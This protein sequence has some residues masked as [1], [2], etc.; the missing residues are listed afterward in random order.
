MPIMWYG[1]IKMKNIAFMFGAGAETS[2]KDF[3]IK[4]GFNFLK[5]SLFLAERLKKSL[6]EYFGGNKYFDKSYA[7]RCDSPGLYKSILKNFLLQKAS[8][9]IDFLEKY[10]DIL[11]SYLS[12]TDIEQ[13]CSELNI[14]FANWDNTVNKDNTKNILGSMDNE[15][16][17]IVKSDTPFKYSN[18]QND[19]LK[20]I[21]TENS[22]GEIDYD[23]NIAISGVLD[24]YFHTIINP[25]KYSTI[26]F[27]K[28]F[29]F[30]WACYFTILEDVLKFFSK[31]EFD[32]YLENGEKI[33]YSEVLKDIDDLTKQLYKIDISKALPPDSYY[34][35]IKKK[36]N[37]Y[38]KKLNCCGVITTNYFKFC[39][40][41]SG[42]VVYLNGQL[43]YFE[44]PEILEVTDL[45]A[46]NAKNE[47]LMF[48]FIFSQS[49]VKPIVN[50]RQIEAFHKFND[51]LSDADILVVLGFNINEDDNHINAFLHD[52]VKN[53]PIIVVT[54]NKN[55][56][57]KSKLKYDGKNIHICNVEYG[58]NGNVVDKM[59]KS[60][61]EVLSESE[62]EVEK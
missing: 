42:N 36:L 10:Y 18:I 45:T 24:E 31:K 1:G 38:A 11:N 39:E 28:I 59:F 8:N 12:K 29:N 57:A 60:I 27:S 56:D 55:Y 62:K 47:Y 46:D 13:I 26:N 43:K 23:V 6:K 5:A 33:N 7:Y 37:C 51:I 30:Y 4:N 53:K 25:K 3:E 54:D 2:E 19:I 16:K 21:F 20:E 61:Q 14:S 32:K 50:F 17:N 52:F 15:F 41:V 49:L 34:A 40:A 58:N 9:N 44:Y 48:P 35:L 22:K